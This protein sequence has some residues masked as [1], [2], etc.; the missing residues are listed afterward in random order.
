MPN[1]NL[2]SLLERHWAESALAIGAVVIAAASL[3]IAYDANLT[4]RQLVTSESW[5]FLQVYLK[6]TGPATGMINMVL[7]NQGIGPAKLETFELLSH[8]KPQRSP[9]QLLRT[10]CGAALQAAGGSAAQAGLLPALYSGVEST[11]AT[12]GMVIRPGVTYAFLS[13]ARNSEDARGWDTLLGH[14]SNL[15]FRYCYCSVFN[16]C[17][18]YSAHFGTES[19]LN[20]PRVGTC[21]RPA[22]MYENNRRS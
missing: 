12:S 2:P 8:G 6:N 13:Y 10:C 5:P 9:W 4:N 7:S 1:R 21:P 15:S 14:L 17:W 11:S 19:N 16:Q 18:L 3:W 22:T 20:P